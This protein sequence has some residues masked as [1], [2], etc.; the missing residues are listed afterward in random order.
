[1]FITLYYVFFHLFPDFLSL[2]HEKE[3]DKIQKVSFSQLVLK[4]PVLYK[5]NQKLFSYS[6]NGKTS[7]KMYWSLSL[8]VNEGQELPTA[9]RHSELKVFVSSC[10]ANIDGSARDFL[11]HRLQ[12]KS[13]KKKLLGD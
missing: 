1:M 6:S 5:Y 4:V 12:Q 2:V 10:W 8:D 7:S 3:Q 13:A 11:L 9:S